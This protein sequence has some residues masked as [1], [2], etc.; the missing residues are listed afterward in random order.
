MKTIRI[1][2]NLPK[3]SH[4]RDFIVGT[5]DRDKVLKS[6]RVDSMG[7]IDFTYDEKANPGIDN[8]KYERELKKR[9]GELGYTVR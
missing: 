4:C 8:Y 5:F 3:C 9:V 6:T 1:R 2:I 7:Y